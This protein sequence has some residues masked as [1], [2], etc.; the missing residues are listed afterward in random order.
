[1]KNLGQKETAFEPSPKMLQVLE[2]A[3]NSEVEANI[4]AWCKKAGV[5]RAQWYRWKEIPGFLGWFNDAYQR[6]LE[7]AR[8]ALVKVGLQK[9]MGGDFQFWKVMMEKLGEYGPGMTLKGDS[10][11]PIVIIDA[12]SDPYAPGGELKMGRG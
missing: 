5:S 12:G 11:S 2:A 6:A 3:V 8:A 9:A 10:E 4:S 1:M 7:G